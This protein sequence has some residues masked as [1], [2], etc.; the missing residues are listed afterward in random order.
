[1]VWRL[2]S[3][4]RMPLDQLLGIENFFKND[5]KSAE[6]YL[7]NVKRWLK[8]VKPGKGFDPLKIAEDDIKISKQNL[9]IVREAIKREQSRKR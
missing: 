7:A 1:M 6:E 4:D 8:H 9:A 5:L 3:S 2:D